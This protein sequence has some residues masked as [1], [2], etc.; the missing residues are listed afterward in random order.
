[1]YFILKELKR[2][3]DKDLFYFV[4]SGYSNNSPTEETQSTDL[5]QTWLS[6]YMSYRTLGGCSVRLLQSSP[7]PSS[8]AHQHRN[9]C[10]SICTRFSCSSLTCMDLYFVVFIGQ[11]KHVRISLGN[12]RRPQES[13]VSKILVGQ[14][15]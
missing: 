12:L 5:L 11:E 15:Y 8:E 1:M 14:F 6:V 4:L 7:Q 3:K 2:R 10:F 13:L 9:F